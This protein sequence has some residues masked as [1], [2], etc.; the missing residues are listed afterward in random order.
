MPELKLTWSAS[1]LPNGS[2]S[3][4]IHFK[5]AASNA[6]KNR[7]EDSLIIFKSL[8]C[9][10]YSNI[11]IQTNKGN[12][13]EVSASIETN[14]L[15][16][17]LAVKSCTNSKDVL[18]Q[19]DSQCEVESVSSKVTLELD[20][21]IKS[22][23]QQDKCD[24]AL[25]ENESQRESADEISVSL[26]SG[27]A[28]AQDNNLNKN[29]HVSEDDDDIEDADDES[30]ENKVTVGNKKQSS[31]ST[32]GLTT[33]LHGEPTSFSSFS[34]TVENAQKIDFDG[35]FGSEFTL[36][37]WIRRPSNADQTIKE[38][39][40]CGSDSKSMNR[41]HYGLYFYRGNLKFLLRKEADSEDENSVS[42]GSN[43]SSNNGETFY[44]SLWE[45]T[46]YE[47]VLSDAKWHFYE[48]KFNY[49]NA[50]LYIDGVHFVENKTNSDIID[51]YKLN[52]AADTGDVVSYV[53]ACY[54]G[55]STR[56]NCNIYYSLLD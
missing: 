35:D 15:F 22:Q 1:A 20:A 44:P 43:E 37:A 12:Q 47:P 55:K 11:L 45:W 3:I 2:V 6:S 46:I 25:S 40:F 32:R 41:H 51:A 29:V 27:S 33:G 34:K 36:S 52:D 38:Q 56:N 5:L 49:P 16:S 28:Q 54:H 31:K 7:K 21:N 8:A 18:Y 24:L 4:T 53:G 19:P 30:D 10:N 26:Y 9:F 17:N 50:S 13:N 39:V 42:E 14:K 23:C 48:I